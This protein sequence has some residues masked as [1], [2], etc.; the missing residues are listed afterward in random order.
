[1]PD[2][3][4]ATWVSHSSISDFLECPRAYYLKNVYKDPRTGHKIYITKPPLALGQAVHEVI[5]SL[6][7][8]PVERRLSNP[9]HKMFDMVWEKVSGKKGGFSDLKQ[10]NEHKARG[11]EMLTYVEQ[12]PEP[13]VEKAVKIPQELPHYWLHEEEE[14]ILCG[15]VDWLKWIES[16]DTVEIYDFKTGKNEVREGSLQLPIYNLLV[17]NT[18]KREV[19]GVF[20]WYLDQKKEPTQMKLPNLEK[21]HEDILSVA[22]RIKLARQINRYKCPQ[23]LCRGC[24]DYERVLEGQGELVGVSGYNQDTYYLPTH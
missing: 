12:N 14:I 3:Y 21:A 23:G 22:R 8:L 5:E 24:R 7:V 9:L 6:S 19:S 1:M 11:Y 4:K 18:Q 2:K 13:L 17:T 20:Y 10:E 16:D 15:K